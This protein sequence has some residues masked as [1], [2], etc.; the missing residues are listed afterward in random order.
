[1]KVGRGY[2]EHPRFRDVDTKDK[3]H[4]VF[5]TTRVA[6]TSSSVG[7]S[8]GQLVSAETEVSVHC[9]NALAFGPG[10]CLV[11]YPGDG[12][13]CVLTVAGFLV[14][15]LDSGW[16]RIGDYIPLSGAECVAPHPQAFPCRLFVVRVHNCFPRASLLGALWLPRKNTLQNTRPAPTHTPDFHFRNLRA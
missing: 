10:R 6:Q 5:G 8:W 1:V 13:V 4:L 3:N 16:T 12:G 9:N 15:F 11:G 7:R 14:R 2:L